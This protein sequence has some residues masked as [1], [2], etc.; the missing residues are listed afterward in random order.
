MTGSRDGDSDSNCGNGWR[1]QQRWTVQ[2]QCDGNN[3]DGNESNNNQLVMAAM[4]GV[5]ATQ[6]HNGRGNGNT[7]AAMAM[8]M[9]GATVTATATAAMVGAT[10]TVMEGAMRRQ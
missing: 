3:G 6:Q 2:R 1:R 4:D 8:G 7:T 9:E 5:M 10:A